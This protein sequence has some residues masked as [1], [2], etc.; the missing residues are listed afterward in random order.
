MSG[1]E[2][3]QLVRDLAREYASCRW[4][5]PH[6]HGERGLRQILYRRLLEAGHPPEGVVATA[7][8]I[9]ELIRTQEEA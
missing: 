6:R 5:L 4:V 1:R 7:T 8:R 9:V 2:L 3:E